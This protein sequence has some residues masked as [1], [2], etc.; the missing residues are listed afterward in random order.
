MGKNKVTDIVDLKIEEYNKSFTVLSEYDD[1]TKSVKGQIFKL[2]KFVHEF[3]S[4]IT[5]IQNSDGVLRIGIVGQ[6]KAGKSSFIN[7]LLFEGVNIL[8]KA[9]TPMTAALTSIAYSEEI[10]AEVEYYTKSDWKIIED[11]AKLYSTTKGEITEELTRDN[12]KLMNKLINKPKLNKDELK[13]SIKDKIE[14]RLDEQIISAFELF[15]QAKANNLNLDDYLD[16]TIKISNINKIEDLMGELNKYVG[17]NGTH[18][19]FTR[20]TKLYL[21]LEALKGIELIDTPGVNDPIISRGMIT[22]QFLA[23]CD[24]VFLLS[25]AGQ[26]MGKEDTSF[27]INTLPNEGIRKI[28]LMGSKFDSVLIDEAKKY[29]GNLI[30]A[31]KGVYKKLVDQATETVYPVLEA[32]SEIPIM[33]TLKES[34]PPQFISGLSFSIAMKMK[35]KEPL[36]EMED[37]ILRQLKKWF[38]DFDLTS[39]IL[40]D[41]ANITNIKEKQL[42]EIK[43]QTEEIFKNRMGDLIEGQNREYLSI[44]DN[45]IVDLHKNYDILKSA[46]LEEME[47]QYKVTMEG[48]NK[49]EKNIKQAFFDLQLHIKSELNIIIR[50]IRKVKNGFKRINVDEKNEVVGETEGFLGF[51]KSDIYGMVSYASIYDA[52]DNISKYVEKTNNIIERKWDEIIDLEDLEKKLISI[53]ISCVDTSSESYDKND[54]IRPLKNAISEIIIDQYNVDSSAYERIIRNNFSGDIIKGSVTGDLTNMLADTIDTIFTDI[55][56]DI[57]SQK[58]N[59]LN[60]LDNNANDFIKNISDKAK[61]DIKELKKQIDNQKYNLERYESLFRKIEGEKS[62]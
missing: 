11:S 2:E 33:Q 21:N 35:N 5:N 12:N 23:K 31:M 13:K 15:S 55:N 30:G 38:P 6:V 61:E 59:L 7:A 27:L 29:D 58:D 8:P 10:Y 49:A 41:L 4:K 1:I 43:E 60:I 28:I 45:I 3:K 46:D 40:F 34:L 9:S 39:E 42:N 22:R 50:D 53:V 48:L 51:F 16:K 47:N 18:T 62:E 36:D 37:H 17:A 44:L 26:F 54:I 56:T 52:I 25:Y 24:C 19:P 20:N 14:R 32:N 57:D